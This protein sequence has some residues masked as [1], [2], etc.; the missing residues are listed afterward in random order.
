MG[1]HAECT[2]AY[3]TYSAE[4]IAQDITNVDAVV[5]HITTKFVKPFQWPCDVQADHPIM[6]GRFN[7]EKVK[8]LKLV[9]ARLEEQARVIGFNQSGEGVTKAGEYINH[10]VSLAKGY[11]LQNRHSVQRKNVFLPRSEIVV[12]CISYKGQSGGPCVNQDGEVIG[13]VSRIHPNDFRRCYLVPTFELK[14][15]LKKAKKKVQT[16]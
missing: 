3:F 2:T 4:I 5:L 13:I 12:D 1:K 7:H 10:E 9:E 14:K 16:K 11:V 15:I 6:Y 8:K